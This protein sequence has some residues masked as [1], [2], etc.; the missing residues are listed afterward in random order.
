MLTET[1]LRISFSVLGRTFSSAD[2]SLAARK[3]CKK[4]LV[5]GGFQNDLQN[6]RRLPVSIFRVK[7]AALWSLKLVTGRIFKI[8]K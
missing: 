7:T 2:L 6:H 4:K 5:T 3:L 8:S 1:L